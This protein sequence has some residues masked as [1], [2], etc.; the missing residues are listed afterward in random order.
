VTIVLSNDHLQWI[1]LKVDRGFVSDQR[2]DEIM[3][4][5]QPDVIESFERIGLWDRVPNAGFTA[6]SLRG[7]ELWTEEEFQV[8][9][10]ENPLRW[11]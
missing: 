10:V 6:E 5:L 1:T 3:S 8:S 11:R 4:G 2:I 7:L 9:F